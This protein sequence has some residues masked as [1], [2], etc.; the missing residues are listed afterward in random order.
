[1]KRAENEVNSFERERQDLHN[2]IK[3]RE[4]SAE[5]V[6]MR[7]ESVREK[8]NA[9]K[10]EHSEILY[11]IKTLEEVVREKFNLV[12]PDIYKQ[13]LNDDFSNIE[14]EA[15][16]EK[17]KR[18]RKALGEVNL[19]AIKEHEALKERYEF[20]KTQREDLISSIQSLRTAITKINR[21]S[22][23]KFEMAFHD[24]DAKLKEIFPILFGGGT[25]GLRLTDETRPLESGVLVEVRPPGKKLS[26]MGLLSGGEK[27]LVAMAFLFAIYMIKPSPFC[28]LDEVDAPL[29]EANVNRFNN[30]LKEIQKTS[31]IIMVTHNRRTMEIADRLYGFTM[32]KAGVSS[33]VSVDIY[34][35]KNPAG[36]GL[37]SSEFTR[38]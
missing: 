4:N 25:A 10:M 29:D 36:E 20:I 38:H 21:T 26:H 8:I 23:E 17:Y 11:K 9:I 22:V 19:T 34:G 18:S 16:I 7:I 24:V 13:Y 33:V 2:E 35:M 28:L 30:L 15:E 27:A 12:L 37:S 6:R 14:T 31:Q 32:E 1:M 3:G 5:G